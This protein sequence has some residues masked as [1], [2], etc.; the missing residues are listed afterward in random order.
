MYNFFRI[1][2]IEKKEQDFLDILSKLE[3]QQNKIKYLPII[4]FEQKKLDPEKIQLVLSIEQD[5]RAIDCIK[6]LNIFEISQDKTKVFL[7]RDQAI[8]AQLS[9]WKKNQN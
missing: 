9:E 2:N 7:T 5:V 1:I 3:A 6:E 4:E 8:L